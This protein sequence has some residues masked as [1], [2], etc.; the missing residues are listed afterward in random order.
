MPVILTEEEVTSKA[1]SKGETI[2][3]A[4]VITGEQDRIGLILTVTGMNPHVTIVVVK[5][6]LPASAHH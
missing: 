3:G 5:V 1:V 4:M 2:L 6:T